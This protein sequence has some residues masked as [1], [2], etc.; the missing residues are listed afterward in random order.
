MKS[1]SLIKNTLLLTT[2]IYL[3]MGA[4]QSMAE[5]TVVTLDTITIIATK[6]E[7]AVVD[8]LSGTSVVTTE[9]LTRVQPGSIS[10][11]LNGVPGVEV[12]EDSDNPASAINIRGLQDFG[13]VNVM[14]D[15]ARQ[16]FQASGHGPDGV[17]YLDPELIRRVDIVR[18]PVSAIYGSGAIAGVVNF[19]LIEASDII[20]PDDTWALRQKLAYASNDKEFLSSTTFAIMPSEKF[21]VLGNFIYR[22]DKNYKDGGGNTIPNTAEEIHSGYAKAIFM[23]GNGNTI[24]VGYLQQ[25]DT[26][27]TGEVGFQRDTD[28]VDKTGTLKWLFDAP[29]NPWID[30]HL[31]A[32]V[33][34][35]DSSQLRL[36]GGFAGNKRNFKIT[37]VG[38]DIFN[39]SV[40]DTGSLTHKLTYGGDYF[41]DDVKTFDPG[42]TGDEFTPSGTRKAYGF[43]I[44]DQVDVN[45]WLRF[46]GALR[47]DGYKLDGVDNNTATSVNIEGTNLSPKATIAVTPIEGVEFYTTYAEAYRA[48]AITETFN[49]GLHDPAFPFVFLPNPSLRP[50]TAHNIEGG[51][52]LQFD[53][54]LTT[55]DKL[56]AKAT[57]YYNKVDDFIEGDLLFTLPGCPTFA[58]F[59]YQNVARARL[60]GVEFEADYD[61]G[62]AFGR[63]AYTYTDGKNLD[64]DEPLASVR[65]HK[66]VSTFGMRF[67]EERLV[68]G[69][70]WTLVGKKK[71]KDIPA[72]SGIAS[73]DGYDVVDL[74]ATY[75]HNRYF[76]TAITL[77]NVLDKSYTKYQ[78]L[79]ASEGFSAVI[80]A[81]FQLG[82]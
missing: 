47:Y 21:S 27:T 53:E 3:N 81:T 29:D 75:N 5:G 64:T 77:K 76:S 55:A 66:L 80:S 18:G 6:T 41:K 74:F 2:A 22:K 59:Q 61:A 67:M 1:S 11:V 31:S 56:R 39:T 42:N 15:G 51:V 44:Q 73:S 38:T 48:P 78:N 54:V 58:C 12:Q 8:T 26:Y 20:Y 30:F 37:T 14:I 17:F 23:P 69:I 52:N 34:S 33:T 36:D 28:T 25:E 24:K 71:S 10:E 50:E 62:Y 65:P 13:R 72:T 60:Q 40:F 63:I 49:S 43:F 32:Y 7:D 68:T 16:N 35:T 4:S 9:T 82:G 79:N 19:E 45:N 57:V 70:T 46:A